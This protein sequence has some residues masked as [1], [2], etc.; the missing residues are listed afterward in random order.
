MTCTLNVHMGETRLSTSFI[1]FQVVLK[2]RTHCDHHENI[3]FSFEKQLWNFNCDSRV[4]KH[5]GA[6][7]VLHHPMFLSARRMKAFAR[8]ISHTCIKKIKHTHMPKHIPS[9]LVSVWKEM[10]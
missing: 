8:A 1:Q 4:E 5:G 9:P 7:S 3:L 2:K 6:Q 10:F